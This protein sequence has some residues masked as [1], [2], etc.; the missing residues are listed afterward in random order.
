MLTLINLVF[1]FL[2]FQH[3]FLNFQ[4]QLRGFSPES[5]DQIFQLTNHGAW[6]SLKVQTSVPNLTE[7][8]WEQLH[9]VEVTQ[10]L[11]SH[12]DYPAGP[13]PSIRCILGLYS[14]YQSYLSV[15][16]QAK[17]SFVFF[18]HVVLIRSA[19]V[20]SVHPGSEDLSEASP[21]IL[22][23]VVL[24]AVE[25]AVLWSLVLSCWSFTSIRLWLVGV[26][27]ADDSCKG[28]QSKRFHFN[29]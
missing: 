23:H 18:L 14:F 5:V 9:L 16:D 22:V 8:L 19:V 15:G 7:L 24:A 21:L 20:G 4:F 26:H 11:H 6:T 28:C 3:L 27:G 1:L 25:V 2:T 10:W 17:Q 29:F 12:F 13:L